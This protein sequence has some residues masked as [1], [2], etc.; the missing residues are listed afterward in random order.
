M[1]NTALYLLASLIVIGFFVLLY[2]LTTTEVPPE[3][4]DALNLV[5][6]AL[7]GSFTSIISYYFGSSKGSADKTEML[8][9]PE[10]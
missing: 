5:I 10:K 7:I 6:G 3:N 4:K 9:K 2:I 1:K 8:H